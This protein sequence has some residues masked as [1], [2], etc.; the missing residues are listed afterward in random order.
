MAVQVMALVLLPVGATE[1][2]GMAVIPRSKVVYTN[3]TP[4]SRIIGAAERLGRRLVEEMD[5]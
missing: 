1:I 5:S 4:D 2:D 3:V